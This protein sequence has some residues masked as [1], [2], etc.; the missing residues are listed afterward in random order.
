M[1]GFLFFMFFMLVICG[2]SWRF[3]GIVISTFF[4]MIFVLPVSMLVMAIGLVFCGTIILLPI[5]ILILKAGFNMLI[6]GV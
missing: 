5:G 4:W 2:I 3:S 6:P 1:I